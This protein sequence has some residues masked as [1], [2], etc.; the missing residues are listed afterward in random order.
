MMVVVELWAGGADL[1]GLGLGDEILVTSGRGG[2]K[3]FRPHILRHCQAGGTCR[4]SELAM[5]RTSAW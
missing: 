1:E 5:G 2:A 3:K 4:V